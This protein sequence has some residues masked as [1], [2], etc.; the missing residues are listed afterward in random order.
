M[1]I[2][3]AMRMLDLEEDDILLS[4]YELEKRFAKLYRSHFQLWDPDVQAVPTGSV[5]EDDWVRLILLDVAYVRLKRFHTPDERK[6]AMLYEDEHD[7]KMD[8]YDRMFLTFLK[9]TINVQPTADA[10]PSEEPSEYVAPA[11][12]ATNDSPSSGLSPG[13]PG[14]SAGEIVGNGGCT[15]VALWKIGV[16]ASKSDACSTLNAAIET[17]KPTIRSDYRVPE[18]VGV[19]D[20][21]WHQAVVKEAVISKGFHFHKI[22]IAT[23]SLKDEFKKGTF[24]VDGVMNN[25]HLRRGS[26]GNMYLIEPDPDDKTDP[27][28]E[29][30]HWRHSIAVRDGRVLDPAT[31]TDMSTAYLWLDA[32]NVPDPDKGYMLK[33]LKV[34]RIF[35]CKTND[36]KCRGECCGKS[37]VKRQ[38]T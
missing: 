37:P 17:Y 20:D 2:R 29:E 35:K 11:P 9:N 6:E 33:I 31:G 10:T 22:D 21:R 34:Y 30:M 15:A 5:D 27:R 7:F 36:P 19:P 8:G 26:G 18:H 13:P 12:V 38:K 24:L 25:R 23:V 32:N 1:L 14:R 28:E 4:N 3:H 16:F